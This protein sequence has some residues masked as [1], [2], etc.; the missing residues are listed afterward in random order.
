MKRRDFLGV[1]G[2][3]AAWPLAAYAQQPERMRRIGML[4]G[5]PE[6]DPEGQRWV[7]TFIQAL[8][9]LGWRSGTNVRIDLHWASDL[10]HM[11]VSAKE[12][13]EL[14]P[15]LIQV[16]TTPATAE[17]L[18]QTRTIPVVFS[19]VSDPLGSGFVQSL[20]RPGGN[21]TGFINLESSLGG[22]WLEII[23]EIAPRITR[24]VMLF[25]P[26]TAPQTAYYKDPLEAAAM[27]FGIK[28][29]WVPIRQT[30]EIET[31]IA[32]LGQDQQAGLIVPPDLFTVSHRDLISS[33]A[34]RHRVITVYAFGVL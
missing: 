4:M 18:R 5:L 31:T 20:P 3:A 23:K 19:I 26:T 14:Q 10:D 28:A 6:S 29:E 12:L 11:R 16:T 13:I 33:L 1:L 22:K 27:S 8:Q 2:G 15:D 25:N 32:A 24:V 34:A 21:A 9:E 7:Q 17:V 30:A